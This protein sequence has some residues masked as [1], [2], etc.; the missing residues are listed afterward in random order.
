MLGWRRKVFNMISLVAKK[1]KRNGEERH[2]RIWLILFLFLSYHEGY[3]NEG[4]K[5]EGEN[6]IVGVAT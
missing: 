6:K 3:G 5:C 1:K 2:F 4:L